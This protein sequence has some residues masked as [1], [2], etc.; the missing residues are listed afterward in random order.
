MLQV[1]VVPRRIK[2]YF[3]SAASLQVV[4]NLGPCS[5]HSIS[6]ILFYK[7]NSIFLDI[8][9]FMYGILP[10]SLPYSS[11]IQYTGHKLFNQTTEHPTEIALCCKI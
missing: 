8:I 3:K 10:I 2:F 4:L 5:V 11:F 9:I 1:S 6:L 7:K